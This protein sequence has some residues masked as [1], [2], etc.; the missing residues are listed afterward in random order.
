VTYL[1]FRAYISW[2]ECTNKPFDVANEGTEILL[3]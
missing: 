3:G 2:L 1:G